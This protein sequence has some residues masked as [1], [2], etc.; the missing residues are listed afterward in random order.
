MLV[1][2][3]NDPTRYAVTET[4]AVVGPD[5][6]P[7]QLVKGTTIAMSEAIRLGLVAGHAQAGHV[8]GDAPAEEREAEGARLAVAAAPP[9][10]DGAKG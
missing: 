7:I 6:V 8:A 1:S 9:V 10:P 4:A 5:G 2:N 3:T